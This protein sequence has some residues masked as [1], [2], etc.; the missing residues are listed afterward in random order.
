MH[1]RS[2]PVVFLLGCLLPLAGPLLLLADSPTSPATSRTAAPRRVPLDDPAEFHEHV[3][4]L[5]AR[6]PSS[7]FQVV[8]QPPFVVV[9]DLPPEQ[10]RR[11][12]EGTVR[13]AVERLRKDFFGRNPER[14]IDVW[15]FKDRTSYEHHTWELFRDRPTTPYGYYSRQHNALI[16]NIATGGGT[17]V[18]E[19]VHP[20]MEA[21]FPQCP[22]WFNEG[23]ASLYEQSGD[24]QGHIRGFTNWR[25]RG[26]QVAIQSQRVPSFETLCGTT[27]HQFY[28]ED[29]G[30][31]YAQAR[32]L[33]YYL[34]EAGLLARFYHQF[35]QSARDDPTG[36]QTL[37]RVL[38]EPEMR[39]F[40]DQ[41]QEFV[42]GL[43]FP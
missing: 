4:R 16:M 27:T 7:Q 24:R 30:T 29:P 20:F 38:G 10:L 3:A 40:Q 15:L 1:R 43:R 39:E 37:V 34:Q 41:W 2:L 13:W 12:A 31:N 9:G 32:Y 26:L 36:Y 25:L 35:R 42:L 33:C 28:R 19:I 5:L 21:N 17:L 11:T 6:L 23:L 14:I 18:H 22:A 8:V